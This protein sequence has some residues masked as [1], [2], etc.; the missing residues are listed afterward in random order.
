ML[1]SGTLDADKLC[2]PPSSQTHSV[3]QFF[4]CIWMKSQ[5]Y[6]LAFPATLKFKKIYARYF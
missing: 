4:A 6:P 2:C 5:T 3:G 1:K